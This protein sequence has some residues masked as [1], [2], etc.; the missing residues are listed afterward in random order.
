MF[1]QPQRQALRKFQTPNGR[2]SGNPKSQAP[3]PNQGAITLEQF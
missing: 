2:Y 1:N 3:N